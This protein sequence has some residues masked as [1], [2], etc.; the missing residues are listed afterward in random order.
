MCRMRCSCRRVRTHGG[1]G[2]RARI[3]D[4]RLG[5]TASIID[6]DNQPV[7]RATHADT[8]TYAQRLGHNLPTEAEWDYAGKAGQDGADPEKAPRDGNGKPGANYWQGIFPVLD[9]A[10]DG[11]AHGQQQGERPQLPRSGNVA[12]FTRPLKAPRR[13]G[14]GFFE[15]AFFGHAGGVRGWTNGLGLRADD[16]IIPATP[17]RRSVEKGAPG[18]VF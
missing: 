16:S 10:E 11:R 17:A 15:I 14:F 12:L 4:T 3:G 18:G 5:P 8:L 2:S 1:A 7:T 13:G 9:T 6:A